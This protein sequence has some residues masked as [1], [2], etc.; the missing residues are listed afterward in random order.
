M[1]KASI[2]TLK[3]WFSL[4]KKPTQEQFWDWI[5]SYVHKDEDTS[6]I[7]KGLEGATF[8]GV[9]TPDRVPSVPTQ[10]VFYIAN[11]VGV[12]PNYGGLTVADGEIAFFTY[13]GSWGKTALEDVVSH[14]ILNTGLQNAIREVFINESHLCNYDSDDIFVGYVKSDKY[15][16]VWIFIKEDDLVIHLQNEDYP[17][18][19]YR[20]TFFNSLQPNTESY[21]G[22]NKDGNVIPNS[23]LCIVNINKESNP[24]I[25]KFRILRD[26]LDLISPKIKDA[27]TKGF[28]VDD[29]YI[30]N[31]SNGEVSYIRNENWSAI[32]IPLYNTDISNVNLYFADDKQR[33]YRFFSSF[34]ICTDSYISKNTSGNVPENS[35]VCVV[36]VNKS[37]YPTYL[38]NLILRTSTDNIK[39][40]QLVSYIDNAVIQKNL[41]D[42]NDLLYGYILSE[43]NIVEN[44]KGILSNKISFIDGQSYFFQN[45]LAYGTSKKTFICHF[46][47]DDIFLGST[48]FQG[49]LSSDYTASGIYIYNKNAHIGT[50]YCRVVLQTV[51]TTLDVDSVQIELGDSPTEI[52]G[53]GDKT[54][55]ISKCA[56]KNKKIRLLAIGNSYTDDALSYVPFIMK[57]M[58][59]D[60]EIG[61]MMQSSSS[62]EMHVENWENQNAVYYL[63]YYNGSSSWQDLGLKSI[64]NVLSE[65]RWDLISLQQSSQT[66]FS[67]EKYQPWCNRLINYITNY[68][69]YNI[70]F[71]WYQP[72]ARPAQ[73]NSG[74]NW[75][76]EVITE[77]YVNTAQSSKRLFEETLVQ[78][79]VPIGTAIQNARTI[80]AVKVLG[81]YVD[82]A[83]NTSGYG[84][85]TPNDGVHLQEGFPC[86]IAAYTFV[87]SLLS[88]CGF[89]DKSILGETTRATA[90]WATSKNIPSP[91]GEYID[92]TDE[93]AIIAQKCAVMAVKKP[94]EVTDMNEL[95]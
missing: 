28:F 47:E 61:I 75:S 37:T 59:I 4:G 43:G 58:G 33:T 76:D 16:S 20:Y 11:E 93:Y 51:Y 46:N 63:R 1:S 23:K 22:H 74:V 68:V 14:N 38:D 25:D 10:K 52:V 95:L 77:H 78:H 71:I 64:Q 92:T 69:N 48:S 54:V 32:W 85:L 79:V 62:L 7:L 19:Q 24:N 49:E 72:M 88:L 44:A 34:N 60:I 13:N 86:Q 9:A 94:Y 57:N 35:L 89:S 50:A 3:R 81:D 87:L 73:I 26:K 83:N 18:S 90:E 82:N 5:D 45:I 41:I 40:N 42:K 66:A 65:Y 67:W 53:Y 8:M 2:E 21:I 55:V 91:H 30:A 84:Y 27:I 36:N 70:K 12:Y 15:N 6:Y 17:D 56:D 39:K 29:N 31:E 80:T